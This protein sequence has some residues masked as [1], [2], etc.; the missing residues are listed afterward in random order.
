MMLFES[1]ELV[2]AGRLVEVER[3][4]QHLSLRPVFLFVLLLSS[5]PFWILKNSKAAVSNV[6]DRFAM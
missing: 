4:L 2:I 1:V 3:F 5:S 6:Q